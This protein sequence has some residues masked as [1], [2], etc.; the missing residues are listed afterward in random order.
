MVAAP[1]TRPDEPLDPP[2]VCCGREFRVRR[3]LE[4]HARSHGACGEAGCTFAGSRAV[5]RLHAWEAHG[6]GSAPKTAPVRGGST[7][8]D[9]LC[10]GRA[11]NEFKIVDE[12]PAEA[13]PL[14]MRFPGADIVWIHDA[15]EAGALGPAED[16]ADDEWSREADGH[17]SA[18]LPWP[19]GCR[20]LMIVGATGSGKT[21]LL[22]SLAGCA[23]SLRSRPRWPSGRSILD[24]LGA[25][26][27]HWLSAVGLGS[28]PLW[29]QPHAALSTGEAFRCELAWRLQWAAANG[30][31]LAMDA[32]CDHLDSLS[33]AC[34]AASLSRH[35]RHEG[36]GTHAVLAC[37]HARLV[38]W[39]R[40]DAL[41]VCRGA[42]APPVLLRLEAA[43][44]PWPLRIAVDE[45]AAPCAPGAG[46]G[47][48]AAEAAEAQ[49]AQGAQGAC[50]Q[51]VPP[52]PPPPPP[53]VEPATA[54]PP[55]QPQP[56]STAR[57]TPPLPAL[58]SHLP[59]SHTP[60]SH[61]PPSHIPRG[62]ELFLAS[63]RRCGLRVLSQ[64]CY[65]DAPPFQ[66]MSTDDF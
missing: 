42:C 63:L 38:H 46:E 62:G 60:P 27:A 53:S 65:D 17:S 9:E 36:S 11:G 26:G 19:D 39:L 58:P 5:L 35:L 14:E 37:S 52:P 4:A 6:I 7:L 18:V 29:M 25:D 59:P 64:R 15:A 24:G 50:S 66:V 34:C 47:R 45:R 2:A 44:V 28:V 48:E 3:A 43:G 22:R 8:H 61:T 31:P 33:A 21:R 13:V 56:A 16:G 32:F 54:P 30:R 23:A 57:T 49:G 10:A 40:P 55:L 1:S 20:I 41:I 51:H 12:L